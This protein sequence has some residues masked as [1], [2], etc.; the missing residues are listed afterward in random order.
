MKHYQPGR[1]DF[2]RGFWNNCKRL[3]SHWSRW[4]FGWSSPCRKRPNTQE[5]GCSLSQS[6]HIP[7]WYPF[8]DQEWGIIGQTSLLHNWHRVLFLLRFEEEKIGQTPNWGQYFTEAKNGRRG[9]R[10]T[11][12]YHFS[13]YPPCHCGRCVFASMYVSSFIY[14]SHCYSILNTPAIVIQ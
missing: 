8:P 10:A 2:L 12:R 11:S 5:N 13:P 3:P 7:R 9:G 14:S 6:D 1:W 4:S